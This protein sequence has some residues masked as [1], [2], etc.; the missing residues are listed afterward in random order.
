[1]PKYLIQANYIGDGVKGLLKEGG[2]SRRATIEKLFASS[3]GKVE[4]FY[5]AFGDTDVFVIADVPD[6]E[7]ATAALLS[8]NASGLVHCKTTV[9]MTPE[10][11]D[12]AVKKTVAYRAPGQ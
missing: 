4:A 11:V 9:L 2:S 7:T 10:Q 3:G 1:M 12:A 5:Y 8:V 6:N